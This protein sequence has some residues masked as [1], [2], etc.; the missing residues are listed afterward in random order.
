MGQQAYTPL[1][2]QLPTPDITNLLEVGSREEQYA[3]VRRLIII[4]IISIKKII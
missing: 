2:C 4:I 1:V 3:M